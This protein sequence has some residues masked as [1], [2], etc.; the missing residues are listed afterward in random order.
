MNIPEELAQK[1]IEHIDLS[2]LAVAPYSY[3]SEQYMESAKYHMQNCFKISWCEGGTS[4]DC[5]SDELSDVNSDYE[6]EMTALKEFLDKYYPDT[7]LFHQMTG[8]IHYESESESD[9]YGGSISTGNKNISFEQLAAAITD[10]HY[11]D[12]QDFVN[13]DSLVDEHSKFVVNMSLEDYPNLKFKKTLE[14]KLDTNL[15][16]VK[17]VKI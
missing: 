15:I 9:Y 5:W 7:E 13:F 8:Y 10:N 14:E 3:D 12:C 17:R 11:Q 2:F 6:P 1:L 16:S 4:G